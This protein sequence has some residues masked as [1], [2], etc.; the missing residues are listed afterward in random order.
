MK[1]VCISDTHAMHRK[2]TIPD[3]DVLIHAGD[4]GGRGTCQEWVDF[5]NWLGSLPHK[6][7][8]V[9][10][11]N[12]DEYCAQ[13]PFGA[14]EA[15]TPGTQLLIDAGTTIN[16]VTFWASP[17]TPTFFDWDFMYDRA[18]GEQQWAKVP[19][20]VDVLITHG[21]PAGILDKVAGRCARFGQEVGDSVGCVDLYH[22]VLAVGPKVHVFG[23]IH[24]GYGQVTKGG[25]TFVN[26]SSCTEHYRPSNAPIVVELSIVDGSGVTVNQ[27]PENE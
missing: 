11:G 16:G 7:K 9:T 4:W 17:M 5:N 2:L 23:H 10:P 26:A 15:L 24:E 8:I 1:L 18:E 6:H 14:A 12:H 21:P 25:T 13:F 3:G 22:R 27:N 19:N 20:K